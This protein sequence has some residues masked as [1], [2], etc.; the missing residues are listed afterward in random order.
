MYTRAILIGVVGAVL[1]TTINAT[2]EDKTEPHVAVGFGGLFAAANNHFD[3]GVG[4]GGHVDF[5][6]R[7][8]LGAQLFAAYYTAENETGKMLYGENTIFMIG[9]S[10]TLGI[11]SQN[12]RPYIGFG[13]SIVLLQHRTDVV[14]VT[15][16]SFAGLDVTEN[17]KDTFGFFVHGGATIQL[18]PLIGM[19]FDLRYLFM[20]PKYEGFIFNEWTGDW[21]RI[22]SELNME[23]VQIFAGITLSVGSNR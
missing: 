17:L 19:T 1:L 5:T 4:F 13:P 10:L 2:A 20:K 6:S 16:A 22:K 23:T 12:I 15:E 11:Q 8:T 14:F 9:G 18:S 7:N 21:L 3:G